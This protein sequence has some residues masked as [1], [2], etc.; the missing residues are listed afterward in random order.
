[1]NEE[2][3]TSLRELYLRV[4]KC[5]LKAFVNWDSERVERWATRFELAF[6][7]PNSFVYHDTALYHITPLLCPRSLIQQL[8]GPEM[9]RLECEFEE[10]ICCGKSEDDPTLDWEAARARVEQRLQQLGESLTSTQ[11]DLDHEKLGL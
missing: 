6:H 10:I 2:N 8:R 7:N 11:R 9:R 1:M 5:A 3:A 4:W